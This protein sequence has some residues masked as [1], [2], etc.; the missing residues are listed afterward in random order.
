MDEQ[1]KI[2]FET[3]LNLQWNKQTLL[4]NYSSLFKTCLL[5]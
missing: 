2:V 3:E 5:C 1:G 4:D